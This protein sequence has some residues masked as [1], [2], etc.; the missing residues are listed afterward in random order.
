MCCACEL[1]QESIATTANMCSYEVKPPAH[2]AESV[3][4]M[5]TETVRLRIAMVQH[6]RSTLRLRPRPRFLWQLKQ[7]VPSGHV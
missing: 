2:A 7:A 1:T 5:A 3:T 6:E 4:H